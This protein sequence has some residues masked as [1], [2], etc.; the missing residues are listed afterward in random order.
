M[1]RLSGLL[2][3]LPVEFPIAFGTQP[4][5]FHG[6]FSGGNRGGAHH[7]YESH[8]MITCRHDGSHEAALSVAEEANL[9]RIHFR[10]RLQIGYGGLGIA[11]GI[12]HWRA[13]VLR[14]GTHRGERIVVV[15]A[16]RTPADERRKISRRA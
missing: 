9:V 11:C 2:I 7:H 10:A 12:I 15:V 1:A 13:A 8:V 16:N 14:F 3:R 5:R 4:V 6:V